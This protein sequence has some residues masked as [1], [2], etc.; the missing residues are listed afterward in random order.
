MNADAEQTQ[1]VSTKT[2]KA[3]IKPCL[4]GCV[5]LA[6]A[7]AFGTL[8]IP[9]SFE[10]RPR[11]IPVISAT[12]IPPPATACQSK[13]EVKISI[14]TCGNLPILTIVITKAIK[15]YNPAMIGTIHSAT[16]AIRETPPKM[17]I[18]VKSAITQP[19]INRSTPNAAC[20]EMVMVL[21]CTELKI[22]PKVTLI[23]TANK[24]AIK[25]FPKTFLI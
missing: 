1:R 3:W 6:V 23:K 16:L 10:N 24:A 7:A 2:P 25:L 21:A 5:A 11:L 13:A 19:T 20:M 12:P 4:T 14:K 8:P 22:S 17:T 9:A 15:R 18:P